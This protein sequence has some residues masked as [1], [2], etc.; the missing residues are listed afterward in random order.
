MRVRTRGASSLFFP[1]KSVRADTNPSIL[2]YVIYECSGLTPLEFA[3]S[4]GA[5]A[6]LG[7]A[8]GDIAWEKNADGI[9]MIGYGMFVSVVHM[10]K[11][12]QL[13]LQNGDSG[14][15]PIVSRA[16]VQRSQQTHAFPNYGDDFGDRYGYAWWIQGIEKPFNSTF[17][18]IGH[19]GQ[20]VVLFQNYRAVLTCTSDSYFASNALVEL[21]E[22]NF[23]GERT[24][25]ACVCQRN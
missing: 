23:L 12:G 18:A 21:V 15:M 10:A 8:P 9:E 7:I 22:E 4:T 1:V 19:E 11:L 16:W 6:A 13:Y 3:E 14:G 2:A 24:F 20:Y 5:F 17:A 25:G